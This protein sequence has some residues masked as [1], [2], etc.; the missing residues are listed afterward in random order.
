MAAPAPAQ[1]YG[2]PPGAPSAPPSGQESLGTNAPS[3]FLPEKSS[4]AYPSAPAPSSSR[5]GL[6][7]LNPVVQPFANA[8][9]SIGEARAK[10]GLPNP[11]TVE[12]L[13]RE[14][15]S[16]C[17]LSLF[18]PLSACLDRAVPP[19][20]LHTDTPFSSPPGTHLTNFMFD[21]ARADLTKAFS[22]NPIFQVTHAF[23]LGSQSAPPA[24]NFG[25]VV[26]D[27]KV[28]MEAM[29]MFGGNATQE[30]NVPRLLARF[31]GG[32]ERDGTENIYWQPQ[33]K[34]SKSASGLKKV[35]DC[36][37]CITLQWHCARSA[38]S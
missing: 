9:N 4:P 23:S 38:Y 30:Q 16:A 11:G 1:P 35:L 8:A 2:F 3:P 29:D 22:I 36:A 19:S 10:L 15:K 14:V 34:G 20:S 5:F 18:L 12:H 32:L 17:H 21:G 31:L 37:A 28:S 6:G 26:G 24:Y 25:A 27:S 13:Q 33:W 7:F